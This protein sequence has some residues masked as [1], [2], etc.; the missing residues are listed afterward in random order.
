MSE[1]NWRKMSEAKP[2]DEQSCL[3][4]CKHGL[5]QGYYNEKEGYFEGYYWADISWHANLWVPIEE[6]EP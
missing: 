5:I 3:T 4:Q 1:I 6:V 2:S